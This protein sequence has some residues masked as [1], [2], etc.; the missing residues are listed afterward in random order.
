VRLVF[1]LSGDHPDLPLAE[2]TSIGQLI[3]Y[4]PQVALLEVADLTLLS[5]LALTHTVMEYLGEC[6]AQADDF[7]KMLSTLAISCNEPFCG[8]VKKVVPHMMDASTGELER[9]IGSLIL[10]PVSVSRPCQVFR[11]LISNDRCYFGRVIWELDR[12]P[13][14]A[15]KPGNRLFFHPGVMMPR[16][17]RALI[18]ISGVARDDL[19][20][21]MFCGTG[22]T[23][24]EATEMGVSCLGSDA[25]PAMVAGTRINLPCAQVCVADATCLPFADTSVDRIV[26]DLPYGQSVFIIGGDIEN[27][28][29][30]TFNEIARVLTNEGVAVVVS[31]RDIRDIASH[32]FLIDRFFEHRIHRS[33]TRHIMVLKKR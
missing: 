25:D 8:R 11:A 9:M 16:Y 2:A 23:L 26:T 7:G 30:G 1:E 21:D 6:D 17:I 22:G 3:A 18:N 20:L 13:Y 4:R 5:R 10:G 15:R 19:L 29:S 14:H 31:H 32:H 28:Y 12:D 27:L 33:L 24:I